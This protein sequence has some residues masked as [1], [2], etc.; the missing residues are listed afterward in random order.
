MQK[1]ERRGRGQGKMEVQKEERKRRELIN[2]N[3]DELL[4]VGLPRDKLDRWAEVAEAHRGQKGRKR[5][6]KSGV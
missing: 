5:G 2:M 4:R 6:R 3:R 1:E